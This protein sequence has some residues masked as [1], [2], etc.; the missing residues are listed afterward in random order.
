[1]LPLHLFFLHLFIFHLFCIRVLTGC[2]VDS[3]HVVL[4]FSPVSKP[5]PV[6]GRHILFAT[7]ATVDTRG[8][9]PFSYLLSVCLVFVV[10]LFWPSFVSIKY[11][12]ISS[13]FP[14]W[15]S[16]Q[17]A[18]HYILR[19]VRGSNTEPILLT[20]NIELVYVKQGTLEIVP[21]FCRV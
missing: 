10:L 16:I 1:M 4:A 21:Y 20:V 6:I 17:I 2:I 18:L 19:N 5:L 8:T 3:I 7:N 14:Y 9:R 15:L 13:K 11:F 12:I